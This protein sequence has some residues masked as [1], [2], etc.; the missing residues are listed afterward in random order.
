MTIPRLRIVAALIQDN[1]RILISQRKKQSHLGLMWEF[2]GGKVESGE[3][4]AVALT[5]EIREELDLEVSVGSLFHQ[6]TYAYPERVVALHFYRCGLL[7]NRLPKAIGVLCY[8][9]VRLHELGNFNF[10]PANLE[11][12]EK[13]TNR[14]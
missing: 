2:P 12:L 7:S 13:L 3:T 10:P 6:Q 5:R 11:L 1:E 4:D 8:R 14:G 9:W